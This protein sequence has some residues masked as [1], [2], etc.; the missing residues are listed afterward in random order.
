MG[1]YIDKEKLIQHMK[2]VPT[3]LSDDS[4]PFKYPDGMYDVNDVINSIENA[5][6]ED[7]VRL[8]HGYW[9]LTP[10]ATY[11]DT[12]SEE[13]EL[14]IFIIATCSVCGKRH[15]DN[16]VVY[17]NTLY[18]PDGYEFDYEWNIEDEKRNSINAFKSTKYEF[19]KYCHGCGAVM[20]KT[21][22]NN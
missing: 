18:A 11:K 5:P 17:T 21:I 13:R 6:D 15:P 3:W 9:K 7:V 22:D 4:T 12:F 10:Y 19:A 1:K 14:S 20:D 8:C 2:D 16:P